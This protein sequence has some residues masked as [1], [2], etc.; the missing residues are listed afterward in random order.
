M[1]EFFSRGNP[2]EGSAER[3]RQRQLRKVQKVLLSSRESMAAFF[4]KLLFPLMFIAP[5][6]NTVMELALELRREEKL[7]AAAVLTRISWSCLLIY[8]AFAL[9]LAVLSLIQLVRVRKFGYEERI[10]R[11]KDDLKAGESLSDFDRVELPETELDR[12][13][14]TLCSRA[15]PGGTQARYIRYLLFAAGGT[16]ALGLFYLIC[17]LC[18]KAG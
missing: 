15:V 13:S 14:L 10:Y 12:D 2:Y 11:F 17:R 5:A 7:G 9:A 8:G 4:A 3:K 6:V 16:A 1:A 18:F